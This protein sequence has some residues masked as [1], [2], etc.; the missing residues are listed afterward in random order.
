MPSVSNAST[1]VFGEE[2]NLLEYLKK[3]Y[4]VLGE[5]II[6]IVEFNDYY[7]DEEGGDALHNF[8][9]EIRVSPPLSVSPPILMTS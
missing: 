6:A 2:I 1:T 8:R 7:A 5:F 3:L 4:D 9:R